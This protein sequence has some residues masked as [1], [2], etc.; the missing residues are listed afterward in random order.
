MG[1]MQSTAQDTIASL[2]QL[3]PGDVIVVNDP[4][5]GGTHLQDVRMVKAVYHNGKPWCLLANTGHW[6]DIGGMVPGGFSCRATEIEQE[7][8][9]I[10]PVKLFRKD[11]LDV[12]ILDI[13]LSNVRVSKERLGDIRAQVGALKLGEQRNCRAFEPLWG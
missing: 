9:R 5:R 2:G 13:I 10:P 11:E 12:G 3:D 1:V 4:Y 8:L 6:P 7:G